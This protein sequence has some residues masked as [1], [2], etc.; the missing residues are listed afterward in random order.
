MNNHY[1]DL[2]RQLSFLDLFFFD[3]SDESLSLH[4]FTF[5]TL[6]YDNHGIHSNGA[7]SGKSFPL[8]SDDY[9]AFENIPNSV[10]LKFMILLPNDMIEGENLPMSE[11]MMKNV[12]TNLD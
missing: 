4:N 2:P 8:K 10:I 3:S 12:H 5:R 6:A 1:Q 11:F 9:D 7:C